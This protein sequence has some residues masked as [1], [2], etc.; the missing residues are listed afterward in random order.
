MEQLNI[1]DLKMSEHDGGVWFECES[2]RENAFAHITKREDVER[3]RD[4][5]NQ[6]LDS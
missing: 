1:G 6:F 2:T 5:L 4:W 3:I